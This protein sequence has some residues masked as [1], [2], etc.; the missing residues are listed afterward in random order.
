MENLNTGRRIT[1]K[2][3][4]Y[5]IFVYDLYDLVKYSIKCI[6][7]KRL[8]SDFDGVLSRFSINLNFIKKI[9]VDP[10]KVVKIP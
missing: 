5:F 4:T 8:N 3:V 6:T 2:I 9:T 7:M 1:L 10:A